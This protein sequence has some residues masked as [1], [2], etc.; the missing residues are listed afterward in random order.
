MQL[1]TRKKKTKPT[2]FHLQ[3]IKGAKMLSFSFPF[4]SNEWEFIT[5]SYFLTEVPELNKQ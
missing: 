5:E 3:N 1:Q 4:F 2:P